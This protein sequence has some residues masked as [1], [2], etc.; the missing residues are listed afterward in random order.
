MQV[1]DDRVLNDVAG[2]VVLAHYLRGFDCPQRNGSAD[3]RQSLRLW[4]TY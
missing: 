2:E 1:V 3:F 4:P